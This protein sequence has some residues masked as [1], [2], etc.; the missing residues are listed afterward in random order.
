MPWRCWSHSLFG[1]VAS[2]SYGI[3]FL[4]ITLA[5]SLFVFYFF[6]QVTQLSGFGGIR[7]VSHPGFLGDPIT[8]PT[9]LYYLC[10]G[11][12]VLVYLLLRYVVRTPFGLRCRASATMRRG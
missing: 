4:M 7:S 10:L 5:L 3:Y 9:P 1:A 8:H 12:S 6:G 2:R 11:A